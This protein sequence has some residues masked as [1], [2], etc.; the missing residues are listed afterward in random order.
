MRKNNRKK[1]FLLDGASLLESEIMGLGVTNSLDEVSYFI[2][3]DIP[4]LVGKIIIINLPIEINLEG[5]QRFN[6]FILRYP[7]KEL[8]ELGAKYKYVEYEIGDVEEIEDE[9]DI[10]CLILNKYLLSDDTKIKDIEGK[11]FLLGTDYKTNGKLNLIGYCIFKNS[12]KKLS[13]L[14]T[15]QNWVAKCN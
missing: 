14:I 7:I 12:F 9:A 5:I 11:S 8:E 10:S 4:S 15:K 1:I 6:E 13:K 3:C 2:N